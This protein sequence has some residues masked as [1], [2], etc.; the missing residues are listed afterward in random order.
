[1]GLLPCASLPQFRQIVHRLLKLFL[2]YPADV[3]PHPCAVGPSC[4]TQTGFSRLPACVQ[5]LTQMWCLSL[6]SIRH[7][8]FPSWVAAFSSARDFC[9]R[10][11][12]FWPR[13]LSAAP[14]G[15]SFQCKTL[16]EA[17]VEHLILWLEVVDEEEAVGLPSRLLVDPVQLVLRQQGAQLFDD[18]VQLV[19]VAQPPAVSFWEL[20][21]VLICRCRPLMKSVSRA[22]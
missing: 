2:L 8:S 21:Q 19:L 7:V 12:S 9:L 22:P 18:G 5:C 17:H 3:C 4:A 20:T 13:K 6:T 16:F 15:F 10:S 1:M 14:I 11:G